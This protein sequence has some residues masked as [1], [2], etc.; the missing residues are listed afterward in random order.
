[1]SVATISCVQFGE[2]L[3]VDSRCFCA[4]LGLH[5]VPVADFYIF[6]VAKEELQN[7]QRFVFYMVLLTSNISAVCLVLA[8]S[9]QW[10][11]SSL[12]L[13]EGFCRSGRDCQPESCG[14]CG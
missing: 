3:L 8:G 4:A 1:M 13:E 9:P 6:Q 2:E 12:S 7:V 10:S 5:F 11:C 14:I